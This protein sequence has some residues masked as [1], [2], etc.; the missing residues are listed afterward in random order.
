[1]VFYSHGKETRRFLD[2]TNGVSHNRYFRILA[3]GCADIL[4]TLPVGILDVVSDALASIE[5]SGTFPVYPGWFAIHTNWGP[6]STSLPELLESGGFW[7]N[8]AFYLSNWSS[9]ILGFAIFALFGLTSETRATYWRAMQAALR[10]FGRK[11]VVRNNTEISTIAFG[12]R[13]PDAE[14][15]SDK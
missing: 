1:M 15:G 9:V 2:S 6:I 8:F 13:V 12:S 5:L 3:V 14:H 7:D 11:P 10:I 4:L